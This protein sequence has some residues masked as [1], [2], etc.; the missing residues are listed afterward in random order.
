VD[1]AIATLREA[2]SR[3]SDAARLRR[4]L[5]DI[6]IRQ[7]RRKEALEEVN[8]LPGDNQHRE[9]LR[10]AVRGACLAGK[11]EWTAALAYLQTAF[12]CGCRDEICLRWLT[13]ASMESGDL[14][15]AQKSLEAWRSARADDRE[16][17]RLQLRLHHLR[18]TTNSPLQ[19]EGDRR[20][21]ALAHGPRSPVS[22]AHSLARR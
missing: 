9:A 19:E 2:E 5:L 8:R 18:L 22:L 16:L 1:A 12:G 14:D 4:Q 20:L 10:T 17:Q 6:Y 7:N 11:G 21:D 3:L 15:G 13:I